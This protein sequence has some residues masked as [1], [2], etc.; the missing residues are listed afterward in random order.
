MVINICVIIKHWL[1]IQEKNEIHIIFILLLVFWCLIH[2]KIRKNCFFFRCDFREKKMELEI[3]ITSQFK[4]FFCAE[5]VI[6][7][8]YTCEWLKWN[9]A[10]LTFVKVL[11]RLWDIVGIGIFL[12]YCTLEINK[13]YGIWREMTKNYIFIGWTSFQIFTTSTQQTDV[14][15]LYSFL[16]FNSS[17]LQIYLFNDHLKVRETVIKYMDPS[18]YKNSSKSYILIIHCFINKKTANGSTWKATKKQ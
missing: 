5:K 1:K 16:Q 13:F 17:E 7:W 10:S 18:K 8:L 9:Q 14:W 12:R 2:G 15:V 6:S 11:M 4:F 3:E